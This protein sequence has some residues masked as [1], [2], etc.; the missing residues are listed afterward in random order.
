MPHDRPLP[1]LLRN[2]LTWSCALALICVV[3]EVFCKLVLHLHYPF[4]FPITNP[5]A[6]TQD[7]L[8]IEPH[9]EHLHHRE[10]FD[11][12]LE[13][14]FTYPAPV[15]IPYA[16]FFLVPKL[17]RTLFYVFC[18]A[19]VAVAAVLLGNRLRRCGIRARSVAYF[20]TGSFLF[21]YPFWFELKQGNMEIVIFVL[22]ALGVWA[23]LHD[24]HWLAATCFGIAGSMKIYPF[25]LLGLLL[26]RKE[27]LK[28][29]YAL[30]VAGCL[31]IASLWL[32]FPSIAYSW[33]SINSGLADFKITYFIHFRDEQAFD[34]S[35]WTFLKFSFLYS[36]TSAHIASVLNVYIVLIAIAGTAIYFWRIRL[37][38]LI[39]QV[40]CLITAGILFMPSSFDYTLIQIYTPWALLVI[41]AADSARAGYRVRGLGPAFACLIVICCPLSELIYR[42]L[43]LEGRI[44]TL[45]LIA[46]FAVG[47]HYPFALA[48]K[49]QPVGNA[50]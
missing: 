22:L 14:H 27:Y 18:L 8:S 13:N 29:V 15:A 43:T 5:G 17:A 9:F 50:A 24:R 34:H 47:L 6:I 36:S 21:S 4:N 23:F 49:E 30:L 44:K 32:I 38:P 42:G 45:G 39:N 33:A 2:F 12:A 1:S 48:G 19:V 25:F 28:S 11:L 26:A 20:L 7:L 31:T 10:F 37:L 46:L 3:A 40:L 35:L 16:L 41:L